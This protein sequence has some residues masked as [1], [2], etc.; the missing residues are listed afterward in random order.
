MIWYDNKESKE[1]LRYKEKIPII[2]EWIFKDTMG[3]FKENW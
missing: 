2:L 3:G 1:I